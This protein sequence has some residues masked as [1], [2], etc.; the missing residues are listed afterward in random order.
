MGAPIVI[1]SGVAMYPGGKGSVY[2]KIINLIPPHRVYI[3]THLGA[4]AVMA[5]KRPARLNVGIDLNEAVLWATAAPIATNDDA[6]PS[7]FVASAAPIVVFDVASAAPD[8]TMLP[9]KRLDDTA[10]CDDASCAYQFVLGDA[11]AWL[12]AWNWRGD[13]FVYSDPPYLMHTRKGQRP[14]YDFEYTDKQ[15]V[16]LLTVLL[17][18]PCPVAISGYWSE[19]YADML[20][21][22]ETFTF[23]ARTRGGSWAEEWVWMNYQRP[24]RLHDYSHLGD[25]FRER[26]RIKRKKNRWVERL[27]RLDELERQA[28]MWAIDEAGLT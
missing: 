7:P 25:N 3:E 15:H 22:W 12:R 28:I 21:G 11:A 27:R 19:M 4:G 26:E 13:E 1:F 17:S 14:L 20:A 24:S 18:L 5:N 16:E 9:G 2:Q 23:M 6:A 10:I 8:M